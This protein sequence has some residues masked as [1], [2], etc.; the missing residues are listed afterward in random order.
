VQCYMPT[1]TGPDYQR[2]GGMDPSGI[3]AHCPSQNGFDWWL[4]D[5]PSVGLL[6]YNNH[7]AVTKSML[8]LDS[9]SLIF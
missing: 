8:Q 6:V 5:V 7:N 4:R 2:N 9:E 3:V 1:D